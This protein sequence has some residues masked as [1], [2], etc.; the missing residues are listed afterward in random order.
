MLIEKKNK[1][2]ANGIVYALSTED[3]YPIEVTDTFLP[4][5]TKD[6]IGRK[7][8]K[9]DN[10]NLGSRND[11]W[12]IGVSCMSGCPCHCQFCLEED[13]EILMADYT[14]K[15]IQDIVVG[16]KVLGNELL[17]RETPNSQDYASTFNKQTE[18][19][20][21][22]KRLYNDTMYE[23][24]IEN[25]EKIFVTKNHPIAYH[26]AIKPSHRIKFIAAEKLKVG[27]TL[28]VDDNWEHVKDKPAPW[29][30]GWL[31]GFVDG[32]GVTTKNQ[33]RPSHKI[34]ISQ[35]DDF[36]IKYCKSICDLFEISCSNINENKTNK[37]DAL[38][39]YRL[40]INQTGINQL[41]DLKATYKDLPDF[42]RGYIAGM[43]DSE[44]YSFFNNSVTKICNCNKKLLEQCKNFLS[45][46]GVESMIHLWESGKGRGNS[47]DCYVLVASIHRSKFCAVFQPIHKKSK[48]LNKSS[49]KVQTLKPSKIVNIV[50]YKKET[51]VYNF[52]TKDHTYFANGI[53]VHNCATGQLPKWRNLTAEEIVEQVEFILNKNSEYNP[54]DSFEFKIN[55]TRMGS[56]FLNVDNVRKAIEIIDSRYKNVHHFISTI[57]VKG[58]DFSWIKDNITLQVSLHS[59]DENHRHVLIPFP[60]LMTI[61]ELGQIRTQSNLKTTLNMTLVDESDFDIEKLKK[62]FDKDYFFVK[63]SPINPNVVSEGNNLGMGVVE[64]I[65]L[66]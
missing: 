34:S 60:K 62:Y 54:E 53:L 8:N 1:K 27:D 22:F 3:G 44:G 39:N 21:I 4:A 59:L 31:S 17:K 65:N 42:K 14:K 29:L 2:F 20:A 66:I 9:L 50:E 18:V 49:I 13:T 47:K 7:Q 57:G 19:V 23:I 38:I 63:L 41:T 30:L 16:D 36:V 25:G 43:Y 26:A 64:G 5:Y 37:K 61:E 46:L 10:Y 56:P 24:E 6:A 33:N 51:V 15:K 28:Y 55:Y 35:S 45:E 40:V 58:S 12:M 32:D 11:R 48:F 52:E